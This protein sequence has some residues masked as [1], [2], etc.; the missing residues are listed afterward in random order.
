MYVL[1]LIPIPHVQTFQATRLKKTHL[2]CN[3]VSIMSTVNTAAFCTH[4]HRL[5]S[6][7]K[8]PKNQ[9]SKKIQKIRA[10]SALIKI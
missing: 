6:V 10:E 3:E 4:I 8:R 5:L 7:C 1:R 2:F 9:L